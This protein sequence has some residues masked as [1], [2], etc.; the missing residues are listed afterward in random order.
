MTHMMTLMDETNFDRHLQV[1]RIDITEAFQHLQILQISYETSSLGSEQVLNFVVADS[2]L[3][4]KVIR[5]A[6]NG[7]AG[8]SFL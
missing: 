3:L 1:T 6:G 5:I 8:K 7:G 4:L 2:S